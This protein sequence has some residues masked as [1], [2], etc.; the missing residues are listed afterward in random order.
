[1]EI[2]IDEELMSNF[3][4]TEISNKSKKDSKSSQ[5]KHLDS[6]TGD[7][8]SNNS[9]EKGEEDVEEEDVGR[10]V[11]IDNAKSKSKSKSKSQNLN[12]NS[13]STS[14]SSIAN[15]DLQSVV[16]IKQ[17]TDSIG[18]N[19]GFESTYNMVSSETATETGQATKETEEEGVDDDDEYSE[20]VESISDLKKIACLNNAFCINL[21][22]IEDYY[23]SYSYEFL[24]V[25]L[26][27]HHLKY[28]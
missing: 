13:N 25:N 19:G 28:Y 5:A 7:S 3:S 8:K 14:K 15:N 16:N 23:A 22:Y 18:M 20:S 1:L 27:F 17:S 6:E 10:V 24:K 9:E 4:S 21:F 11:S 12:N 2:E 26:S